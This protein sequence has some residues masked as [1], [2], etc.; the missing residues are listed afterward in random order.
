MGKLDRCLPW[1]LP[2]P[3]PHSR[4]PSSQVLFPDKSALFTQVISMVT[5]PGPLKETLV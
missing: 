4:G 2:V 5:S 1:L 3:T